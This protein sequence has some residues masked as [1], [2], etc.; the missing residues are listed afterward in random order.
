M[1]KFA[2]YFAGLLML[3]F[4]GGC[5]KEGAYP[6]GTVSPYIA[7]F[8][9]R[10]IYNGQDVTL[11]KEN[12]FGAEKIAGVVISDH[13]GGNT[14]AGLLVLQDRRRLS[15]LRGISIPL[16]TDAAKYV[17]GDSLVITVEGGVLKRINGIL[18]L[19]GIDAGKVTKVASGRPLSPLI[20]KSNQVLEAPS[21]YESTLISVTRAGFDQ[22]IPPGSTYAGDKLI[23][24]GF[25]NLTLH[26]EAGATFA[27]KTLPFLSNFAGIVFNDANNVPKLWPRVESDITILSATAPKIASI[28]I[29]GYLAD[30]TGTDANYE[31]IQL[32]A[33][34]NIDFSVTPFAIVT[35]N[36]AGT[37]LFPS[38]GWA[39]GAAR[40]YKFDLTSGTVLKGQYF[41]VGANKNIWGAGSTDISS[42]K[43]FGKMYA[44]VDG[45][46]FGTKTTNLLA[47]SGNG[48]GIAVFDVINVDASTI[49]V[50]VIFYGGGGSL[51]TPGPPARGYR[52]TNTD[53]YDEKNPT[54]LAEQPYYTQGSNTGKFA[55]PPAANYAKLGGTYNKTT[56]RWTTARQQ[57]A[58]VL[59]TTATVAA[60]EGGTTLEE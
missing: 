18:Q 5:K 55:F 13:S 47:N 49:P 15:Q 14:P 27:N 33:T 52:I 21:N 42:S 35:N 58:I 6:G 50:D 39:T 36:N 31:Y 45:D 3:A 30:P 16:G 2:L 53:Y 34:R 24:D 46:G 40:S 9:I 32:M 26:T 29:T 60:I 8:D 44:T 59:T 51:Y 11:T 48:A 28:I 4:V 38:D 41:Y 23:N 57:T 20:V 43:W 17:P 56:G 1:K 37:T 7:M 22:N 10:Q 12:M 54:T 19:T 25:G